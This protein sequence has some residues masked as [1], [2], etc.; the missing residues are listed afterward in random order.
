M[1]KDLDIT[2]R[3]EVLFAFVDLFELDIG[4]DEWVKRLRQVCRP[5][6]VST[7]GR[8]VPFGI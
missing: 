2:E 5:N 1:F 8:L 7:P 3:G 6:L 4:S